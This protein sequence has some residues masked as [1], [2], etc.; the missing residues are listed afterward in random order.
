[1]CFRITQAPLRVAVRHSPDPTVATPGRLH[2][3]IPFGITPVGES[4]LGRPFFGAAA[5]FPLEANGHGRGQRR[6]TASSLVQ[7]K[8]PGFRRLLDPNRSL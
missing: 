3:S 1:M 2:R 6:K 8:A 5:V 7:D 4:T